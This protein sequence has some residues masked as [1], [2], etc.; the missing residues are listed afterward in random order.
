MDPAPQF[1]SIDQV[2]LSL[3][4]VEQPLVL[5]LENGPGFSTLI[6]THVG[7]EPDDGS[8]TLEDCTQIRIES[9]GHHQIRRFA[10]VSVI[11]DKELEVWMASP[12]QFDSVF[13]QPSADP[14]AV[15]QMSRS[16]AIELGCSI[17]EMNFDKIFEILRT[18]FASKPRFYS[19]SPTVLQAPE[20]Y[21]T[22]RDKLPQSQRF[23]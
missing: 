19:P 4:A 2:P 14:Y 15:V 18:S 9:N 21:A 3:I 11:F 1:Q 7:S 13:S 5:L 10:R 12:D 16:K 20:N 22:A 23:L 6:V 8:I 17:N